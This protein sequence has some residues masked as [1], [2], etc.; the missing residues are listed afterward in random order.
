MT[1]VRKPGV[2]IGWIMILAAVG[3]FAAPVAVL[4]WSLVDPATDVWSQLWQT[5]LPGMII[6]SVILLA[7]VV[8]GTLVLGSS[9]AWLVSA[10]DFP[11]RRV[12]SWILVTPLAIP[13]YVGGFVWLDTL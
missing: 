7:A 1:A 3:A 6:D 2:A 13:G 10:F 9:L 8:V 4:V 5:R 12:F 11:G